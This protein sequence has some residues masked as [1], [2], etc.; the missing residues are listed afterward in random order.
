MRVSKQHRGCF[1]S[2]NRSNL[3]DGQSF[4]EK[5]RDGLVAQVVESD[6]VDVGLFLEALPSQAN[7]VWRYRKND[8]TFGV[9]VL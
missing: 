9:S 1:M 8:I 6:V 3:G 5:P 4:F 2:A 7:G